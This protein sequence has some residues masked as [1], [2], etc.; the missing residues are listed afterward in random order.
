MMQKEL[1]LIPLN[2]SNK[3]LKHIRNCTNEDTPFFIGFSKDVE[4]YSI[5]LE[6]FNLIKNNLNPLRPGYNGP[7]WT[8]ND[9]D[10]YQLTNEIYVDLLRVS[11]SKIN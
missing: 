5:S 11:N 2:I 3:R 4:L 10:N 6:D 9:F 1:I 8:D 7:K